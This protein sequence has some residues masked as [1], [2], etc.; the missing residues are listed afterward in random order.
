MKIFDDRYVSYWRQR[1]QNT[2]D[3][4]KVP[5]CTIANF[6][7]NKLRISHNDKI[8]DIGCSYGRLFTVLSRYTKQISGA[9]VSEDALREASQY[10]Y[11]CLLRCSAE[12]TPIVS[13][14]FDTI[15]AWAVYD[16]VNQ[17]IGLNEEN[18]ILKN[19]GKL[20]ITGKNKSYYADDDL[21]FLAE[22]N[23]KMKNFPNHFTDVYKLIENSEL[24]GFE[25]LKAFGFPK[26]GDLGSNN[27]VDLLAEKPCHFYEYV[28]ILQKIGPITRTRL[29]LAYEFSDN[30]VKLAR[31]Y[32]FSDV[33]SFFAWHQEEFGNG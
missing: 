1:V 11:Y 16:V 31:K 10:P 33:S 7:I 4:S 27:H 9:D 6:Y 15:I 25:V 18:R 29:K 17:E 30:A 28:L 26:R 12:N 19:G 2:D 23:A 13:C 22:R 32:K 21:A 20:L 3:G 14:F 24:F 8:L 5:D